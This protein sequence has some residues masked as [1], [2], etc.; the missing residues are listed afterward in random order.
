MGDAEG[1][2]LGEQYP[3]LATQCAGCGIEGDD[4]IQG[5]GVDEG[6]PVIET[7]ISVAATVAEGEDGFRLVRRQGQ[8][9]L[10][11]VH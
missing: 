7:H 3:G 10:P 11:A 5:A 6:R 8:G 2:D 4:P 1:Q 9:I